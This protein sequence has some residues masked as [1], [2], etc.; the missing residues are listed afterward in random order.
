M[1]RGE[2]LRM[3]PVYKRR[4]AVAGLG[5]GRKMKGHLE[6]SSLD[7]GS[8]GN[9]LGMAVNSVKVVSRVAVSLIST[10]G[11]GVS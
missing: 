1:F 10:Q 7:L 8:R 11:K 4:L 6:E 5:R 9:A 3:T 2:N